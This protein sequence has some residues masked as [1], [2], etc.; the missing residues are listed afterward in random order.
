M[1]EKLKSCPH[2]GGTNLSES[3]DVGIWPDYMYGEGGMPPS[4]EHVITCEI[5]CDTCGAS[6]QSCSHGELPEE[7]TSEEARQ[8]TYRLWNT[9]AERTCEIAGVY[10]YGERDELRAYALSCG[11]EFDWDHADPP[12]YCPCCGAK[13]VDE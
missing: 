3:I 12:A 2:C 11:H 1:I 8:N 13:V 7:A 9:R 4:Y 5:T 10:T 6:V